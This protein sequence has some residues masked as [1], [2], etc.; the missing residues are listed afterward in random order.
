MPPSRRVENAPTQA[1]FDEY[2]SL[3]RHSPDLHGPSPDFS[4]SPMS[5]AYGQGRQSPRSYPSPYAASGRGTPDMSQ[6]PYAGLG[7]RGLGD[8][9]LLSPETA[10][11]SDNYWGRRG[12]D[13]MPAPSFI[14]RDSTH[15]S[16][17][18]IPGTPSGMPSNRNSWGSGI[19]LA[20][21]AGSFAGA[22]VSAGAS[23]FC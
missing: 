19:A 4:N 3:P 12:S 2:A 10:A 22:E 5:N 23:F 18:G 21:A 7:G 8:N 20:G 16:L 15:E 9:Q 11:A 1:Q 17:S 14:S 13:Y 6:S